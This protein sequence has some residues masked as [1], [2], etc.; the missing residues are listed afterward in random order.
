MQKAFS[1]NIQLNISPLLSGKKM[2]QLGIII[3]LA[4]ITL[5][6]AGCSTSQP[7]K[8][9]QKAPEGSFCMKGG[10][11]NNY[12]CDAVNTDQSV[13]MHPKT[14]DE[15]WMYETLEEIKDWL[16]EERKKRETYETPP[17]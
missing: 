17:Q 12:S 9:G 16:K 1:D 5:L 2:K 4:I 6:L 7:Q 10:P 15:E 3:Q 13:P 14:V 8:S 11:S